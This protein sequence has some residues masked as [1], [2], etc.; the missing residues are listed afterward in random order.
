MLTSD[1]IQVVRDKYHEVCG[2]IDHRLEQL[3]NEVEKMDSVVT[4]T[5]L[6][7][8]IVSAA[9]SFA[10]PYGP[11][12]S[13]VSPADAAHLSVA[14]TERNWLAGQ[15]GD[16]FTRDAIERQVG[17]SEIRS[18][19]NSVNAAY[20]GLAVSVAELKSAQAVQNAELK[21]ALSSQE[22]TRLRD[23][24]SNTKQQAMLDTILAAIAKKA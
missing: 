17:F 5:A 18:L 6:T 14:A 10:G 11:A 12:Y 13:T 21:A 23:D 7:P 15:F 20:G 19:I 24:L 4:P 3:H 8:G 22:N 1:E 16:N 9:P 2:Y